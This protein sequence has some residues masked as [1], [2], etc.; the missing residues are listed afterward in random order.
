MNSGSWQRKAF[1]YR[2][3]FFQVFKV[4]VAQ[5]YFWKTLLFFLFL[6]LFIFLSSLYAPNLTHPCNHQKLH[7][8]T[9]VHAVHKRIKYGQQ[10]CLWD[11]PHAQGP[12]DSMLKYPGST[13]GLKRDCAASRK[14]WFKR[15]IHPYIE[16]P[17]IPTLVFPCTHA[18]I[19]ACIRACILASIHVSMHS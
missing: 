1:N 18:C 5:N 17:Q 4:M 9:T 12:Y 7:G 15:G 16:R 3:T 13:E 6:F 14:E 11:C 8:M 2:C 19:Y 10:I